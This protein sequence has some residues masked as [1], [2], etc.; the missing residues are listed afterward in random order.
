[1]ASIRS[2]DASIEANLGTVLQSVRG[3]EQFWLLKKSDVMAMVREYGSPTFFLTF[4]S[5]E[6]SSP[7][8]DAYLRKVNKV[9]DTSYKQALH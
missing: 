2:S 4:S 9:S 5:A 3:H 8:I 6:Y 1:M 7:E